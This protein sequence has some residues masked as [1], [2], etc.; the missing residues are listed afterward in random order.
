MRRALGLALVGLVACAA[1]LRGQSPATPVVKMEDQFEKA[2]D[3][4]DHRGDVVVLIYGDRASAGANRALGEQ[5]HVYYHP[6]AKGQPPAQARQAPVSPVPGAPAGA[7]SPDVLAVPVACI[8]KVP[9][10]VAALIRAHIRSGAPDVPVWLDFEDTMKGQ[11]PFQ[12]GVPNVV[13]LDVWGRLRYAAAGQPT[14]A[15]EARLIATI[16]GL[17]K[18]GVTRR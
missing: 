8:G 9:R 11:F 5:L 17:R 1:F 13:V 18:E 16:D 7:R 12:A 6:T 3:V 10:L 4:A 15:G 2:H 14:A